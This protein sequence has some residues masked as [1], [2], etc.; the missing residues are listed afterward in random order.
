MSKPPDPAFWQL[1]LTLPFVQAGEIAD[2]YEDHALTVSMEEAVSD[3]SLWRLDILFSEEPSATLLNQLP[4]DLPFELA[5]LAQKDWVSESQKMLPPVDAGR[6]YIHGSHDSP[7]PANSRHNMLI[8][9]GAAFGTGLHETTYG[10]LLALDNLRKYRNFKNPLDLGCGSGVLALAI[11]KAWKIPVIASDIDVAAVTVTRDNAAKNRLAPLM[12]AVHATGLNSR[13]LNRQAPY[14]LIVANILA[15]P[16]VKMAPDIAGALSSNGILVLSG[17]LGSQEVMV[18]SAYRQ[19]GL[20]LKR[21]YSIGNW[22]TLILA[23][24]SRR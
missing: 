10:C 18:R 23:G 13:I 9:A 22:A 14:D 7:H 17:L 12:T 1:T 3:G 4:A 24:K 8:D 21:R 2:I 11:A 20:S 16:L 6:F 15:W 19:Q 5:P